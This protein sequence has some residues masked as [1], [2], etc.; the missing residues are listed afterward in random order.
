[1][2]EEAYN[3]IAG[4]VVYFGNNNYFEV[5]S[6]EGCMVEYTEKSWGTSRIY[7]YELEFW[8]ELIDI[9]II[10]SVFTPNREPDWIL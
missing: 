10:N 3:P 6:V 4:M 5:H 7:K 9:V 8:R 1:M 2:R